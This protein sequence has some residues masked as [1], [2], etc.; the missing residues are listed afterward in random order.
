MK[1]GFLFIGLMLLSAC[2]DTNSYPV[3]NT[4][5][6]LQQYTG[7]TD[8]IALC[9]KKGCKFNYVLAYEDQKKD[10]CFCK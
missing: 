7:V 9:K 4:T 3:T 8:C 1:L 6:V 5:T 10:L 2:G